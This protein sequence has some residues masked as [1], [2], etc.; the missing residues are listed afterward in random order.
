MR[1]WRLTVES[2]PPAELRGNSRAHWGKKNQP[3]KDWKQSGYDH[4]MHDVGAVL[5]RIR[6]TYT[7]YHW[8]NID[9]DNLAI[10]MKSWQDG[11][12]KAGVV[13]DDSPDRVVI[14]EHQFVKQAHRGE[15]RTEI[16]IEEIQ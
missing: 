4:G 2:I 11:L 1:E 15:S 13:P 12:V 8:K 6:I 5:K 10:G 7:F 14:G 3:R 16:L 9:R